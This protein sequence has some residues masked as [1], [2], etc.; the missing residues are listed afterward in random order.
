MSLLTIVQNACDEVGL[1]RPTTVIGSTD[2]TAIRALR[3]AAR[4][5]RELV[6]ANL[7]QLQTEHTFNT[8]NGVSTYSLPTDFDHFVPWT[9]WN[10]TTYRQQYPIGAKDW[11]HLNSGLATVSINDRFRLRKEADQIELYPTPSGTE[12]VAYEYISTYFCTDS[13][14]NGQAAWAADTDLTPFDDELFELSIMWR[15]LNR[16]GQP[17]AE[18]KSEYQRTL[19]QHAAQYNPQKVY[20]DGDHPAT[21]NIPDADFPSS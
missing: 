5:G 20:L 19:A 13:G 15:L 2:R 9:H 16:M 4:T 3:F 7:P 8:S 6:R 21:S 18:E 12:T 11:A 1:K 14:G 17:Y 10:R